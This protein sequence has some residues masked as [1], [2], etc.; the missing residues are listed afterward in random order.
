MQLTSQLVSAVLKGY[1]VFVTSGIDLT[2]F[3]LLS[4]LNAMHLV[5][6]ETEETV[7]N[8]VSTVCHGFHLV[9]VI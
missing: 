7:V 1:I 6:T 3:T 4:D 2:F 9:L 8:R 5:H